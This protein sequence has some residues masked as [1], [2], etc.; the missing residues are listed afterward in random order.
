M[1]VK[2]SRF[3][4]G[5]T[6]YH[7]EFL[8]ISVGALAR[9]GRDFM[10]VIFNDNPDVK[11]HITDIRKLGFHGKVHIINTDYNVGQLRARLE[12]IKHVKSQKH[13]PDWFM[14]I[15]DDDIVLNLTVPQVAAQNFAVIQNMAVI[16]NRLVNVLRVMDSADNWCQDPENTPV[17]QPYLGLRGTFV[18]FDA[19]AQ[20]ADVLQDSISKITDIDVSLNFRPPVD[21]IMWNALNMVAKNNNP[22]VTPIYMDCVNCVTID[23]D[24]VTQKY[25]MNT[26][27]TAQQV[28]RAIKKYNNAIATAL[29]AAPSGQ[30]L[31]A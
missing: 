22:D 28:Q 24:N 31:D 19:L 5:M 12:I 18:R 13:H 9:L 4:I 30:D 1:L 14:F 23:I 6:T 8:R 17:V 2:K 29:N 11:I 7:S 26:K 15:D 10:L 21:L 25:G 16:Q 3:V 20:M 27:S